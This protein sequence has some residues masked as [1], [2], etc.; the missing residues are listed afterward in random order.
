MKENYLSKYFLIFLVIASILACFLLFRP[1][2]IEIFISA[3]LV[4]VFY[5]TYLRLCKF[6]KVKRKI[7]ALIMCILLLVIVITPITNLIIFVGKK[8]VVAYSETIDFI[9]NTSE[10]LKDSFLSKFD[11]IDLENDNVEQFILNTTKTISDW[12]VKGAT[13]ILKGTT[14]FLISLVLIVLTMFFF[15]VDGE[16]MLGKL[17]LWSPLPE[18]YNLEIFKKFREISRTAII[19]TFVTAIF[20]GIIGAIGFMIAGLPAFYP[21]LLIAFFSLIPYIGSM[22]IY[23]PIGIYLILVGQVYQGVFVLAWGALIIG[24]TDNIIRAWIL[25][26]KSKISPIFIIFS[27]MGGIALFGF[28]GLV[29]GPLIL[30]LIV[31]ILHIYELEYDGSLEK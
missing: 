16:K 10:N 21:G 19:S 25:K 28:W 6:L 5:S 27:L 3:V 15:F 31:T 22:I 12:L 13:L 7:A 18:K 2:L 20:Q 11:F 24:N 9:N 4:S 1:F 14:S 30:S 8:S 26:G 23:V 17:K 29:L